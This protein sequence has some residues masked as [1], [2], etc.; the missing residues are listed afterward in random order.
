MNKFPRITIW[1]VPAGFPCQD[2]S[3]LNGIARKG[4]AGARSGLYL[5]VVRLI[6]IGQKICQGFARV[7]GD[8]VA[9]AERKEAAQVS[10]DFNV[11]AI[12]A[13]SGVVS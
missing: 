1:V 2:L 5:E 13:C 12:Q 3:A 10:K 9:S 11:R 4:L 7:L 8:N 6:R